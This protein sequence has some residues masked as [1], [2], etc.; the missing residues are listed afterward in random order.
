MTLQMEME[1]EMERT[2][3]KEKKKEIHTLPTSSC[4][5]VKRNKDIHLHLR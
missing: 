3:T 5:A 1:M 2:K 4:V